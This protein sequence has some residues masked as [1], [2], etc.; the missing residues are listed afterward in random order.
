LHENATRASV[1]ELQFG[2]VRL[3]RLPEGPNTIRLQEL[4]TWD[5]YTSKFRNVRNRLARSIVIDL[6]AD[7]EAGWGELAYEGLLETI[8][9][10]EILCLT[11]TN[12]RFQYRYKEADPLHDGIMGWIPASRE[13]CVGPEL[14]GCIAKTGLPPTLTELCFRDG[15][16]D[17][18]AL[19][20]LLSALPA[21]LEKLDL[22]DNEL[23][24]QGLRMLAAAGSKALRELRIGWK[25]FGNTH[26]A[27]LVDAVEAAGQASRLSALAR[28]VLVSGPLSK[29][30]RKRL[31]DR[32]GTVQ[33]A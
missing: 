22:Q 31:A 18:A 6:D 19:E 23:G 33:M 5:C 10:E 29:L 12:G 2:L 8:R 17:A 30:S 24:D 21:G 15:G 16:I 25:S 7:D 9:D 27:E 4:R 11:F 20:L 3:F 14:A 26:A 1:V 13:K 28:L 32:F